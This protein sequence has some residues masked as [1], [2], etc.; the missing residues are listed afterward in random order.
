MARTKRKGVRG[1]RST[2]HLIYNGNIPNDTAQDMLAG[3]KSEELA[4]VLLDMCNRVPGCFKFIN[5]AFNNEELE[6][7]S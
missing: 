3:F 6:N 1:L 5:T 7:Q 4:E 2:L